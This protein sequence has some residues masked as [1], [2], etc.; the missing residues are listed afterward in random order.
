MRKRVLIVH[1]LFFFLGGAERYVKEIAESYV[2]E[3]YSVTILTSK[4]E[5][6]NQTVSTFDNNIKFLFI[7]RFY[8]PL[9][10]YKFYGIFN[11]VI[12]EICFYVNLFINAFKLNKII[13][14]YDY[15]LIFN[16]P[17]NIL[18]ALHKLIFRK[19]V[20]YIWHCFEPYNGDFRYH[21]PYHI[22][23]SNLPLSF[24]IYYLSLG[25]VHR[26][27][28]STLVKRCIT[29][30]AALSSY[31]KNQIDKLYRVNCIVIPG[32]IDL[33]D[34][35]SSKDLQKNASLIKNKLKINKR[36]I[37]LTVGNYSEH[38]NFRFL[39]ELMN[40]LINTLKEKDYYLIIAGKPQN[41]YEFN[42][43]KA[44]IK[45][46]NLS[47]YVYLT[48]AVRDDELKSYYLASD[49]FVYPS[50]RE[51][52]GLVLLEALAFNKKIVAINKGG[53]V[54]ILGNNNSILVDLDLEEFYNG[55]VRIQKKNLTF[56]KDKFFKRYSWRFIAQELLDRTNEK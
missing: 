50:E 24:K 40:Y 20:K 2:K 26:L 34:Y 29:N 25:F 36:I 48:G 30:I 56:K 9:L 1:P 17:S 21:L 53:I 33:K 7:N 11:Y 45:E 46:Y 52:F 15:V 4:F 14:E 35:R 27:I 3:K 37:L 54:D 22:I 19:K 10:G 38:K 6:V 39:V 51:T 16:Y 18:F 31:T 8:Q 23:R 12:T 42:S 44:S 32:G 41:I 28:D 5:D 49:I 47:S 13:E 55:I 43:I